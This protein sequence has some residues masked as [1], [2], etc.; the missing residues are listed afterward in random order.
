MMRPTRWG[1]LLV[2]LA[3]SGCVKQ[4]NVEQRPE[5]AELLALVAIDEL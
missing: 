5:I 3:L 2:L 4:P 1:S